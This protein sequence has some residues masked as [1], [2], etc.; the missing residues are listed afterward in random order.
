MIYVY[1]VSLVHSLTNASLRTIVE[2]VMA[3]NPNKAESKLKELVP[4][5]WVINKATLVGSRKK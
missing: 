2:C 5:G 1:E 4:D 3:D